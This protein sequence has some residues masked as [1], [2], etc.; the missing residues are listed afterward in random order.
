MSTDRKQMTLTMGIIA[1]LAV[2]AAVF[3]WQESPEARGASMTPPAVS[4]LSRP[5]NQAGEPSATPQT[6]P[7]P[8][9]ARP[10]SIRQRMKDSNDWY[11]LAKEILPLARAGDP[12]AQFVLFKTYRDCFYRYQTKYDSENAA[13][14]RATA[15]GL[16]ADDA[17]QVYRQCHRFS[18]DAANSLGDPWDWLQRA[19]DSG[20]PI[21]QATTAKERLLQDQLKA[22]TRAGGSPTDPTLFLPPLGGDNTPREL[23][24][25]AAQSADPEVLTAIG[26]LQRVLNPTQPKDVTLLNMTAW[27]YAACQR[28]ADCSVYGAA[29]VTNCGP[30]DG[31]CAPVPNTFLRWVNDDWTPV[32]EKVDQINAAL[33]AKRWDQLQGL[34][35][36]G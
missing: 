35:A 25:V 1:T 18:T 19:T 6:T 36:A 15:I 24:A 12:E 23:L 31:N 32:Q 14:E 13:R 11:A 20:Y 7:A 8:A 22:A 33:N 10:T 2:V 16:S 4:P 34:I 9:T 21:A 17:A 28:G 30:N 5:S 27:M 3:W 26:N 29:T